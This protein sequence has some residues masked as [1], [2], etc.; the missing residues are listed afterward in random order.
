MK[1]AI[2]G[3]GNIGGAM[4]RGLVASNAVSPS[5]LSLTASRK[6][7]LD[8]YRALGCNLTTDNVAAVRG[9]DLVVLALKSE[10]IVDVAAQL[11]DALDY[12]SQVV[13]SMA[14]GV[15]DETMLGILRKEDGGLPEFAVVIPNIAMEICESMTFISPVRLSDKGLAFISGIFSLLGKVE[16]TSHDLLRAG[17]ALAS[18]GIAFALRYARAAS[19]GGVILGFEADEAL[20]IVG[21]TMVGA[22]RLLKAHGSH[23][24]AEIDKVTTPGGITIRGLAAM[25]KAGFSTAVIEGLKATKS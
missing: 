20:E 16:V 18:C 4:A 24:E 6:S 12:E 11:R 13:V 25:E 9:A 14:A 2:I 23:P 7:S 1:I 19:E 10:R 3:A 15:D 22:M 21:Q 8:K 17:T 5:D